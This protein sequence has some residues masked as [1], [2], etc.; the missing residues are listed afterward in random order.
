MDILIYMIIYVYHQYSI[1]Q[2]V[3]LDWCFM[4]NIGIFANVTKRKAE[5]LMLS[6][7]LVHIL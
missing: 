7:W 5:T 6:V 1:S 4:I 3:G 2:V